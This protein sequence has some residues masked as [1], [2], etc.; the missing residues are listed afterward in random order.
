MIGIINLETSNLSS[1]INAMNFINSR[2]LIIKKVEDL[3]IVDKIILPGVGTFGDGIKSLYNQNLYDQIIEEVKKNKKPIL[4]ICLGLQ[5]FFE[6][7]EESKNIKGLGIIG[8]SVKKLSQSESYSIPRIGWASSKVQKN[9]LGLKKD[10]L[11]DFYYIHSYF[12]KPTDQNIIYVTTEENIPSCVKSEN[13]YGCQF[14][15]EKSH[16]IGLNILKQFSI[17]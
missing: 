8:G 5:L 2:F 9:F 14:H 17:L 6:K 11:V 7:S 12:V 15:P 13:I 10:Q 16:T 3:K 1:V 4:G